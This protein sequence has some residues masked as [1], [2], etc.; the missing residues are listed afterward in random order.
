MRGEEV[1]GFGVLPFL[2]NLALRPWLCWYVDGSG[3]LSV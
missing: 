3:Q 2:D 1:S